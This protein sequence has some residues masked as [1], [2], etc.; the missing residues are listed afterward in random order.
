MMPGAGDCDY[1]EIAYDS[2]PST[3]EPEKENTMEPKYPDVTV[4]LTGEDGNAFSIIATVSRALRNHGVS[5]D[6]RVQFSNEAMGGDYDNL[7][8]VCMKWVT[9]E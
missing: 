9:V 6:E 2:E 5:E 8:R 7:L 4:Q 1:P 3:P